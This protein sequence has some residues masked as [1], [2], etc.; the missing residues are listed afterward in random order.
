MLNSSLFGYQYLSLTLVTVFRN[1]APLVTMAVEKCIMAPEH[2]PKATF[3]VVASM[4]VM[5]VGA[6]LFSWTED[7]FSWIGLGL[8]VVNTF[9]AIFDR[10]LQRRLLVQECKD[11]PLPVCMIINNSLGILPTICVAWASNEVAGFQ[12]PA[13]IANWSDPGILVLVL[14]SGFMGLFIGLSG[15]MCQKAMTATSFQVL[16]NMS[17]VV[18]VT[19]GVYI[20]GDKMNSPGRLIG[21][22]LS[23][24]G[25]LAYGYARTLEAAETKKAEESL[26]LVRPA[27]GAKSEVNKAV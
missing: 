26:P 7:A 9:L 14:M 12:E 21:M 27:L 10:V 5:I 4:L 8:I 13:T 15:L 6:I 17:K 3:P 25:S 24:A 11:L 22:F 18:V 23:L 19:L 16:Q 2:Q 20:F 1:L